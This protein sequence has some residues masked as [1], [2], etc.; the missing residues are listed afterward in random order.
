MRSNIPISRTLLS[1]IE[2]LMSV[3][4]SETLIWTCRDLGEELPPGA[5][6]VPPG[7]EGVPPGVEGVPPRALR[8]LRTSVNTLGLALMSWSGEEGR[9][10]SAIHIHANDRYTTT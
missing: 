3:G 8:G 7:V 9:V 2:A 6:G 10:T 4:L 1:N 5:E